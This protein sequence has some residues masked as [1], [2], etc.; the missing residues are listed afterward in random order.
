VPEEVSVE[1][2]VLSA[3][4]VAA[5]DKVDPAKVAEYYKANQSRY[6]EPEQRR[7]SHILIA[8]KGGASEEEKRKARQ[9]AEAILAK[10]RAAPGSFAEVAKKESADPGSASKG[11]D[12]GFFSRGMMVGPFE[13]AVFQLKPGQTSGVVETDFGYHIIKLTAIKPGKMKSLEQVRPEIEQAL[14]KQESGKHFAEAA[15]DFQNTVYDQPDSLKPAAEKFKLEIQHAQGVTRQ[16]ARVPALNNSKLLAA[17]FS[18]DVIKSRHNTEAVETSP[19]T[20]VSARVVDHKAA[21]L[22]PFDDVKDAIGKLL[23]QQEAVAAA[24]KQ[25]AELLAG[26]KKGEASKTSFDAS[27]LV[28]REDP[29]GLGPADLSQVFSADA[30]RLPAY[31]G[32]DS[33]DGYVV[34]RVSKVIDMKPDEAREKAVQ[35]EL[36]R[37]NGAQEFKS[38][39]DSLRTD[40]KVQI[41]KDALEGKAQ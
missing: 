19:G 13:D 18:D 4:A 38:F 16:G 30:S 20:L 8:V 12:L 39:L 27:K 24:R 40:A 5:A 9:H 3:D 23:A 2:V 26:L 37:V 14:R 31:A 32:A 28:S 33:G 21:S 17:L 41:N 36:G 22:R 1:Y 7:A 15:T 29:K 11:G 25:G 35:S 6:G 10:L 34:Y